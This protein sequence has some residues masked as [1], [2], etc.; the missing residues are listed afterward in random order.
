MQNKKREKE[1]KAIRYTIY[2]H[3]AATGEFK[4]SGKLP[5]G[6]AQAAV[7]QGQRFGGDKMTDTQARGLKRAAKKHGGLVASAG[8]DDPEVDPLDMD[9]IVPRKPKPGAAIT[10][11]SRNARVW[12]RG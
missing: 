10:K 2:K 6:A 5:K 4:A 1:K 7:S 9:T 3:D 12:G 11:P 8:W